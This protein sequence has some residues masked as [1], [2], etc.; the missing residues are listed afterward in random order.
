[1]DRQAALVKNKSS[2]P[3]QLTAEQLV[4]DSRD[5]SD[6]AIRRTTKRKISDV[7]ELEDYKLQKCNEFED[8]VR[9]SRQD[10]SVLIKYAQWEASQKNLKRSRSIWERALEV[11]HNNHRLWL[12]YAEFEM[13]NRFIEHGRNIFDRAVNVLPRVDQIWLKYVHLEEMLGN[14]AGARQIL[15]RWMTW[16]PDQQAW[17]SY[18]NFELRYNELD[19]ARSLYERLVECH[20]RS[21]TAWIKYAKFETKNSEIGRARRVYERAVENVAEEE[22]E[23][24]AQV[25][26]K[27]AEFEV[28]CNETERARCIY[29]FALDGAPKGKAVNLYSKFLAFENQYGDKQGIEDAIVEKR[30]FEYEDEVRRNPLNYDAWFDY[31]TLEETV[32]EKERIRYVFERAILNVPPVKEKSYWQRYIYFWIK[33][34]LYEE[35]DAGD[36]ERA[37]DVYKECLNLIPH[38]RFSFSKVWILAAQL[39]LR[40]LNLKAARSILGTAIGMASKPKIFNEYI[41]LEFQLGNIDRCRTLYEK[42]LEWSPKRCYTWV[43]YAELEMTLCE[44]PRARAIFELGIAQPVLDKPELLWKSYIEFEDSHGDFEHVTALKDRL[45]RRRNAAGK[46]GFEEEYIDYQFKEQTHLNLLASAY[47]W[48]KQKCS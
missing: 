13:R 15:E 5:V 10:T 17:I 42:Y 44:V 21:I 39:E 7:D 24:A 33:Y 9:R 11:D 43:K 16:M 27:F 22:F 26:A 29:K 19:R 48:K 38:S 46:D 20:P 35:L 25:F 30:R 28:L 12:S 23:G 3:V 4:R 47:R 32:G 1:M 8:K 36:V 45:E 34:A 18:I 2:N 31:I 37:R 14:I 6:A 40:A 41:E